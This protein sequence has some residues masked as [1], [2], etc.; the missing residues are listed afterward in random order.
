MSRP[1]LVIY[2][3]FDG[4][5]TQGDVIDVLLNELADPSWR[6]IETEW[7]QGRIGS[8]ECLA[9]QIPLIRGGWQAIEEQL[10]RIEIDPTFP[11]F[12]AWCKTEGLPLWI[13]SDGLDRVIHTLLARAR[14]TPEAVWANHLDESPDGK[15]SIRFPYPSLDGTCRSGV[16]KC[17]AFE[18]SGKET[19]RVVIGD[20]H[21]DWCWAQHAEWVFAKSQLLSY[22]RA[23]ELACSTFEDF[24]TI[25]LA[26]TNWLDTTRRTRRL[27]AP[28]SAVTDV[29]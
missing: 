18:R 3:D 13:V 7:E 11:A 28:V 24:D 25:R 20:G 23:Q 6:L 26:L 1:P 22:C 4:T 29:R 8:R 2:C 5:I 21:S 19:L 14:V 15:L 17:Q 16:C 9:R 10:Q 27:T 12:A